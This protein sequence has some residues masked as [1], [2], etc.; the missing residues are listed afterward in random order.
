MTQILGANFRLVVFVPHTDY[1]LI[2][3]YWVSKNACHAF[4]ARQGIF[5]IFDSLER[6]TTMTSQ[7]CATVA[8]K[9]NN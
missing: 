9:P 6:E 4:F 5:A 7:Y 3:I 2:E 8:V 1:F